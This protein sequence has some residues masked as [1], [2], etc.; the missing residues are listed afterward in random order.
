MSQRARMRK[1]VLHLHLP[2]KGGEGLFPHIPSTKDMVDTHKRMRKSWGCIRGEEGALLLE[3]WH[4][5]ER[6]VDDA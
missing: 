1:T 2:L 3:E 4:Y 6:V 5:Q